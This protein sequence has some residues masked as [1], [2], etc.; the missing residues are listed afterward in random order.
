MNQIVRET[1]INAINNGVY[2]KNLRYIYH[3][4][5][6]VEEFAFVKSMGSAPAMTS[7]ISQQAHYREGVQ[8]QVAQAVSNDLLCTD[9]SGAASVTDIPWPARVVEMYFEDP[10][11]PTILLMRTSHD[12]LQKL[13]P[14]LDIGIKLDDFIIAMMQQG[15]GDDAMLLSL[16][17][18]PDMYSAFLN[19]G[20]TDK[21]PTGPFSA[22]LT[23]EDNYTMAFM[24]HLALKVFVFASIP[25]YKPSLMTRKQMIF[26]GKAG[27]HARPYRPAFHV[28]YLPKIQYFKVANNSKESSSR[29]FR[30]KRGH[31]H[32]Y[33]HARFVN[34]KGTW[35]Y[36]A[37]IVDPHTGK[38]PEVDV[39]KVRKPA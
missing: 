4:S 5:A 17:L 27:V 22:N 2:A 26:G 6:S 20:E 38:Y 30:G 8:L 7:W 25:V 28:A 24:L 1:A 11:L 12:H 16:Q 14:Q 9:F 15:S 35:D 23:E 21:M 33:H 18:R 13:F 10:L 39:I 3:P 36:I 31:I 29:E 19:T 37:P 32:W 34:R